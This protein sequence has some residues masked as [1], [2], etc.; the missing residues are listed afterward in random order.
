MDIGLIKTAQA[1][2]RV[3][4]QANIPNIDEYTLRVASGP[5]RFLVVDGNLIQAWRALGTSGPIYVEACCFTSPPPPE[6]VGYCGGGDVLPGVP[7]SIGWGGFELHVKQLKLSAF[8]D[9]PCI[10]AKGIRVT[11]RELVRYIANTKGGA[12]YDPRGLSLKSKSPKFTLLRELEQ[13]GFAGFGMKVNDRNLV[14]HE[15]YSV[16]QS[17]LRSPQVK[18]LQA[19]KFL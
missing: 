7:L 16:I 10:S 18:R 14:H 19:E 15:L 4:G 13:D 12:H 1:H 6:A 3:L 11:R 9:E 8:L 17:L 2:L 5:L